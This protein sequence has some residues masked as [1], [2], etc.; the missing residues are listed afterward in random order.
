M[1][2]G[3]ITSPL[4]N[5]IGV[6]LLVFFIGDANFELACEDDIRIGDQHRCCGKSERVL[7]HQKRGRE[8]NHFQVPIFV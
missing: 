1:K 7:G 6:V 5:T 3:Q 4:S 8:L 2:G